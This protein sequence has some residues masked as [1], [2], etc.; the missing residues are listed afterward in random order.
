MIVATYLLW[1]HD[2]LPTVLWL[3]KFRVRPKVF[4]ATN[5]KDRYI[6]ASKTCFGKPLSNL[7]TSITV[8]ADSS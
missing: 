8:D 1:S 2:S 3:G 6:L 5:E 4:F 7:T